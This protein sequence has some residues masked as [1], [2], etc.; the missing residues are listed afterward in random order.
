MPPQ[1]ETGHSIATIPDVG[2]FSL[3][4]GN[5]DYSSACTLEHPDVLLADRGKSVSSY[6][7]APAL[8]PIVCLNCQLIITGS[9][10][11]EFVFEVR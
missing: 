5:F 9:D 2:K 3:F 6:Q 8:S 11:I 1:K 10:V 7:S 4:Q